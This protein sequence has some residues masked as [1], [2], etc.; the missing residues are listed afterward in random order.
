LLALAALFAPGALTAQQGIITYTYSHEYDFDMP[1]DWRDWVPGSDTGAMLLLFGS[2]ASLMPPVAEEN[3]S[4]PKM[5]DRWL[6]RMMGRKRRSPSRRDQEVVRD[7]WVDFDNGRVVETRQFMG[8]AFLISGPAPQYAWRMTSEQ[9][10]HLGRL[11]IKATAQDGDALVDAWF[12]PEI[13]VS[14]GPASYGGLP[15]MI[16]VLSLD[17]GRTQYFA[18]QIALGEGAASAI[19][20]PEDGEGVS[21]EE[22]EEIVAEKLSELEELNRRRG[23][24][25]Q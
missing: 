16:L 11:V 7:V 18:T 20:A 22:Y 21:R 2:S 15:G 6:R 19:Q 13:P 4:R 9:A 14:G 25:R 5:S 8:R 23:D 12:T 1:D 10:E 24:D 17:G 3:Q